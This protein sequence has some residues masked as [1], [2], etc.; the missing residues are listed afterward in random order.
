VTARR[1]TLYRYSDM[2]LVLSHEYLVVLF[3]YS[4]SSAAID[5]A[6]NLHALG[7]VSSD[8]TFFY[9]F[10]PAFSLALLCPV[11]LLSGRSE[12]IDTPP[13]EFSL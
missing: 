10:R 3:L 6:E 9:R 5:P 7:K 11:R 1:G 2:K 4:E 13:V 8:A 12:V